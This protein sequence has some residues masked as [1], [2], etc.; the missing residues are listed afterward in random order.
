MQVLVI[1]HGNICRSAFAAAYLIKHLPK[2]DI[3]QGGFVLPGRRSPKKIREYAQCFNI[4]LEEHR[5]R[6][7]TREDAKWADEILYM[8][9]GNLKRLLQVHRDAKETA[10]CLGKY[11]G[12]SRVPDPNFM[13]AESVEF[14]SAM[15]ILSRSCAEYVKAMQ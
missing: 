12:F 5:S 14:E 13:A 7:F 11:L 2:F 6:L 10:N 4:D 15:S 9:G 3:R 8:D 1:C